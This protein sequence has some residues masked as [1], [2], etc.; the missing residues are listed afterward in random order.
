MKHENR[1]AMLTLLC[2]CLGAILLVI[3]GFAN[4]D[5]LSASDTTDRSSS[6]LSSEPTAEPP[7]TPNTDERPSDTTDTEPPD[8]I[9]DTTDRPIGPVTTEPPTTTKPPVTDTTKDTEDTV[10]ETYWWQLQESVEVSFEE[11]PYDPYEP[12]LIYDLLDTPENKGYFKSY[13]AYTAL[14]TNTPQW[15]QIQCHENAY[16]DPNGL[17]KVGNYYCVAMGSFYTRRLG[18]LFEITTQSGVFRVIITDFK[19][20]RHTNETHQYGSSTGCMVEFYV[21][22]QKLPSLARKMGNVSYVYPSFYGYVT[23][24]AY[25][26][27]YFDLYE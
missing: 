21:D 18:D 22:I 26:G 7:V 10:S 6:L 15:K 8:T 2:L 1:N 27:N 12:P 11:E 25:I 19:S 17:R 4:E 24:V 13:T 3:F 5:S 20:D 23:S 16:T 9:P 14:G